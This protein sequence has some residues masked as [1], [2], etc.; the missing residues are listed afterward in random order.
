MPWSPSELSDCSALYLT[1]RDAT[2][3]QSGML[4]TGLYDA[5]DL[6]LMP[7]GPCSLLDSPLRCGFG[8]GDK[9]DVI[10]LSSPSAV[11]SNPCTPGH[12]NC[13]HLRKSTP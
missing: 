10:M 6:M 5:G 3:M 11:S 9:D 2:V 12:L 7:Q 4:D 13:L 1:R 8:S